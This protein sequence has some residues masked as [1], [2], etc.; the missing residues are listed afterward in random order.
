MADD[1]ESGVP[2]ALRSVAHGA[3]AQVLGLGIVRILGFVTT[4]L[5]THSLGA[6]LYG[7]Y[8]FGKTLSSIAATITNLGTDQSIVRFIP[9]YEDDRPAQNRVIGLATLTSL[10]GSIVVGSILYVSAPI[11]TEFTLQNPLLVT[12]LRLFAVVLP[13][14]TLTGCISSVFRSLELP[15][16]QIVSGNIGRQ[17]FRLITIGIVVAIGATLTGVLV[18]AVLAWVLAFLLAV[19]LFVIRTDF[20]PGLSGSEPGIRRFYNFSIPLTMSDV[21]KLLLNEIDV[22]MVGIFLPGSAVGIYNLSTVLSQVL[23]LPATGLNTIYPPIA[24]RMYD[25]DEYADLEALFTQVTRWMFTLSLLPAIGLFV[26]SGEIM[27]LFGDGFGVGGTVLSL[28]VVAWMFNAAVGP[29]NYTLMMTDHQ[30]LMMIDRWGAGIAN[31]ILNYLFITRFGLVGAAMAT[32]IVLVAESVACLA[33]IWYTERLFPYS[34]NFLKPIA[35]GLAC[36]LVLF[37]WKILSPLSGFV[38]LAVGG[39]IGTVTFVLVL[40][41]LGIE[42]KDREFFADIASRL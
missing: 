13:F 17:V 41:G 34:L 40:Y 32:T 23:N 12:T 31:A 29:V 14:M 9:A 11:L 16:Y 6:S 20:R 22:L 36:G 38:L 18:A 42:Q 28:F 39:V 15:G 7:I 24:A 37:G 30:Y 27:S 25:N 10:T 21:G 33:E 3:G 8:S 5:L 4:F 1:T 26:F 2:A 35:A 19:G